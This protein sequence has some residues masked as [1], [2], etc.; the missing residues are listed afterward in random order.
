M[1]MN[2]GKSV[3]PESSPMPVEQFLSF[4]ISLSESSESLH[5]QDV[6]HG[7][8]RPQNIDRMEDSLNPGLVDPVHADDEKFL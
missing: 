2:N 7:D 6:I 4:G 8:I 1:E 3:I 5:K